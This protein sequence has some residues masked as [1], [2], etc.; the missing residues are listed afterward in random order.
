M[1]IKRKIYVFLMKYTLS[2]PKAGYINL[3]LLFLWNKVELVLSTCIVSLKRGYFL[4]REEKRRQIV[5]TITRR[6]GICCIQTY[7]RNFKMTKIYIHIIYTQIDWLLL[8][9]QR[10]I[11]HACSG[12]F[13]KIVFNDIIAL[14]IT[15]KSWKGNNV[16]QF[17]QICKEIV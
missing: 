9:V 12:R 11:F 8:N 17:N 4:L 5:Y 7:H 10:Q 15:K 1:S 3:R 16:Q 2:S 6:V 14:I 13:T